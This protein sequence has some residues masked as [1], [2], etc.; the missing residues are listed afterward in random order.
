MFN[1]DPL[2]PTNKRTI[3]GEIVRHELCTG[4]I[5]FLIKFGLT[6]FKSN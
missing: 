5:Y 3:S 4:N 1:L 2:L 6:D